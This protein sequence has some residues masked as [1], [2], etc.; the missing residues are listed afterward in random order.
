MSPTP[1]P[2]LN[3]Q[4][5]AEVLR[6]FT[7]QTKKYGELSAA[8]AAGKPAGE[9]KTAID[10]IDA[11]FAAMHTKQ[12]DLNRRADEIEARM[13][14]PP[15]EPDRPKSLGRLVIEDAGLKKA[16]DDAGGSGRVNYTVRAKGRLWEFAERKDIT[17]LSPQLPQVIAGVA[18]GPRLPGG[19]RV[20][21]PQGSTTAGAAE[22]VEETS[23]T[24]A[25]AVVAEGAPKPKSD[26][27]FTPKILP[28]QTIAHYFKVS[29]Q[30]MNDLP[31][32]AA[33]IEN[34]G[35]YGVQLAEDDE[36]LNG[37]GVAPHLK[38]FNTVAAASTAVI[39]PGPPAPSIIDAI[40][41]SYF[42]LASKGYLPDGA[43]VNPADWGAVALLRNSLGN[44]LFSN[45]VDYSAAPRI[46]GMRLVL[47]AKEPA[48]A[49]LVGAFAGNSQILDREEVNVRIAE[50][51]EDDF[52]KNM[53]TVLVEERL[54]L[55]IFT[56]AA[57]E[58]GV[59]P[60]GVAGASVPPTTREGGKGSRS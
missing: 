51:N 24:N 46:W 39:D 29:R 53:L 31:A 57:F 43:V 11:D 37:S 50:Q 5:R 28:V 55:L 26:K 1:A 3:D 16:L 25:A 22:Y 52:I 17:G 32:V 21:V 4:D 42:A 58:K 12:A 18:A 13:N 27:V 10:K 41:A 56:A 9:I 60:V 2:I 49:Y 23:F 40:G 48:G 15:A 59:V 30:T 34:N 35:I 20:L 38:G 19:V 8:I 36:L 54:V 6:M 44:Y 45:P 47:S 7:E 14:R 33:A